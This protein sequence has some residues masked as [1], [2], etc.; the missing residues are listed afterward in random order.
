M[1]FEADICLECLARHTLG[2]NDIWPKNVVD[3]ISICKGKF[4]K[5][6]GLL[7]LTLNNAT[8]VCYAHKKHEYVAKL[9]PKNYNSDQLFQNI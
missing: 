3:L 7:H 9:K 4:R 5:P 1:L 8:N 6:F 2:R